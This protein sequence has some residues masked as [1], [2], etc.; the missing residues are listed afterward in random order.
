MIL[1]FTPMIAQFNPTVE[2]LAGILYTQQLN[3]IVNDFSAN[4]S[5]AMLVIAANMAV[6]LAL[7]I[8]AYRKKGLRA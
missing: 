3:V 2:K 4:F 1:G 5:K 6:L 8:F 7:F